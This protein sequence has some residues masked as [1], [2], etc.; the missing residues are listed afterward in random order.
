MKCCKFTINQDQEAALS[1]KR[2]VNMTADMMWT[3]Q[4][5]PSCST[6]ELLLNE[7]VRHTRTCTNR[8]W[9]GKYS[10]GRAG[11]AV[12]FCIFLWSAAQDPAVRALTLNY[13]ESNAFGHERKYPVGETSIPNHKPPSVKSSKLTAKWKRALVRPLVHTITPNIV[14]T[15]QPAKVFVGIFIISFMSIS[16]DGR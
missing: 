11:G 6:C 15:E 4:R 1:R 9:N 12:R 2:R 10:E 16:Q 8:Q 3:K 5:P 14:K 7:D 13:G